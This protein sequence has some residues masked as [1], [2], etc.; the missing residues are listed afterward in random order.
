MPIH[1]DSGQ[2]V[3]PP[4]QLGQLR[5]DVR[6]LQSDVTDL[7]SEVRITH[8]RIDA[9]RDKVDEKLTALDKKFEEKLDELSGSTDKRFNDLSKDI[10]ALAVKVGDVKLWAV[11]FFISMFGSLFVVI[12]HAFKWF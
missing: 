10:A 12:A 4:D 11:L 2:G 1:D 8:Q 9:L 7:K 6:H 5:S 3:L